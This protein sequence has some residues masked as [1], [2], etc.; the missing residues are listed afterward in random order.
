MPIREAFVQHRGMECGPRR[1]FS[2]ETGDASAS[3]PSKADLPATA[4]TKPP[5]S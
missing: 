5:A 1:Y 2:F 4:P 3:D